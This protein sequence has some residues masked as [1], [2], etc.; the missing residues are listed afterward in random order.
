MVLYKC[1]VCTKEFKLKTDLERHNNRKNKCQPKI[2]DAFDTG[3]IISTNPP[4]IPPINGISPPIYTNI[5]PTNLI[6]VNHHNKCINCNKQ[7]SRSDSYKRHM[8]FRCKFINKPIKK[9]DNQVI[10]LLTQIKEQQTKS[11]NEIAELKKTI[12]ELKEQTSQS[13]TNNTTNTNSNNTINNTVILKFGDENA[14]NKLSKKDIQYIVN[15]H[16]EFLLQRSIEMTHCNDKYPSLQ[17]IYIPDKK[18]QTIHIYNGKK[19]ELKNIDSVISDL[20]T[21]HQNNLDDYRRMKDIQIDDNKREEMNEYVDEFHRF[22]ESE[23]LY[24]QKLY[25]GVI[26][27]IKLILYNNKDKALE[28]DKKSKKK[29]IKS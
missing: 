26:N 19:Y 14:S 4:N 15:A 28:S 6:E 7:F 24:K 9:D 5:T 8:L 20:I 18:M 29:N 10:E 11:D 21:N 25:D 3:M 22:N 23:S 16:K 13:I 27:D 17:N 12:S 1:L 2:T